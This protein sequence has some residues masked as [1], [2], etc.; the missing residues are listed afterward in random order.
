[1]G[2]QKYIIFLLYIIYLI[3][4]ISCLNKSLMKCR[5]KTA[6]RC[7]TLEISDNFDLNEKS[8]NKNEKHKVL[9]GLPEIKV[10]KIV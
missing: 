7:W 3:K 9:S 5:K 1:M 4:V 8:N 10:L 6:E 2:F